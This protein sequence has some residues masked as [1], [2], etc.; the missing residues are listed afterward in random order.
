MNLCISQRQKYACTRLIIYVNKSVII[1]LTKAPRVRRHRIREVGK[2]R[3][4]SFCL[5]YLY[6][7]VSVLKCVVYFNIKTTSTTCDV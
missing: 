7:D 2:T 6:E 3:H 1:F 5:L 4:P